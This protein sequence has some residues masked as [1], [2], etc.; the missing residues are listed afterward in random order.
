MEDIDIKN[1]NIQSKVVLIEFVLN[2]IRG[3]IIFMIIF[4]VFYYFFEV[5]KKEIRFVYYDLLIW[6][7]K[8]EKILVSFQVY[9][10]RSF[11]DFI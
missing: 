10:G 6:N 8:E 2:I 1:Y 7:R 3:I 4:F 5:N 11:V 9:M